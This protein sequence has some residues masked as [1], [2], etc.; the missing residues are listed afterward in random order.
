MPIQIPPLPPEQLRWRINENRLD[1]RGTKDLEPV[2]GVIGQPI[3]REA[4]RFGLQSQAPGQNIYVRGLSGTGRMTLVQSLLQELQPKARRHCDYCYINDF[5]RPDRPKLLV[6]PSGAGFKL[7]QQLEQM[8]S[9]ITDRLGQALEAGP[10]KTRR[11]AMENRLQKRLSEITQPLEEKLRTEG[12]TLVRLQNGPVTQLSMFPMIMGKAMPP[13]EFHQMVQSGQ[14][15]SEDWDK[16]Q[17]NLK[18]YLKPLQEAS[19]KVHSLWRKGLQELQKYNEDQ[20][21]LILRELCSDVIANVNEPSVQNEVVAYLNEIV[22]DVLKYRLGRNPADLPDAHLRYSINV[23]AEHQEQDSPVVIE[24]MPSVA[25]LLGT[26]EVEWDTQG[27][28]QTNYKSIRAGSLLRADGGYL[29]LDARDLLAEPSAWQIL[30]RTLRSKKLEIIPVDSSNPYSTTAIKPEPIPVNIRVIMIGDAGLYY[31]LNDADPD[32]A[33]LFKV[34]VDFDSEIERDKEAPRAYGQVISRLVKDE[35]LPH[36]DSSAIAAL[37]EHGARIASRRGKVSAR[38][39]RIADIAREAAFLARE[40][41]KDE[42]TRE[43]VQE[44]IQRTKYRA[45]LPTRNFMRL[46]EDKII[47]LRV[48]GT[49]VGQINGLAVMS[50]GSL[51]YGFPTRITATVGAGDGRLIDIQGESDLSGQIHTKGFHTLN[52]LLRHLLRTNYPLSFCASIAFEQHY[53]LIDG[54]SASAAEAC[55]VLSA[56]TNV[57]L[58]QN[59]AITGAIDQ[60]GHLQAIG[61]VNEKIEGFF[62]ACNTLGLT[63]DQGVIIPRVNAGD[64]MLREDVVKACTSGRFHIYAV[65]TLHRALELLS[66]KP[67]GVLIDNAYPEGSVLY[68]AVQKTREY[69][70]NS[71][72]AAAAPTQQLNPNTQANQT[73]SAAEPSPFNQIISGR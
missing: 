48:Q 17:E 57:P 44:A 68:M 26:V 42:V 21:R 36:F 50:T 22:E 65:D 56:L 54:D 40:Q 5:S 64:L 47:R 35:D 14:V 28:P 66:D 8:A 24:A 7:R 60:H 51:N 25:N 9:F 63:G 15:D 23:I 4:M 11:Q 62:D 72:L 1:F 3:A 59:F 73:M 29:V 2:A 41:S 6:M 32:F 10:V 39:G 61:G 49:V 13:E 30:I 38:F 19:R 69:W 58:K 71:H 67:A 27:R 31:E 45:S 18:K 52:G 53:G 12:L 43:L 70:L 33:D 55:C 46:L 20:A 16:Y 34:L 37:T